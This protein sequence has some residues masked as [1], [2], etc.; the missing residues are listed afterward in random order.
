MLKIQCEL[1]YVTTN[2]FTIK[3]ILD[4]DKIGGELPK[5]M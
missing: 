5:K 1:M 4:D 3:Q 2:D